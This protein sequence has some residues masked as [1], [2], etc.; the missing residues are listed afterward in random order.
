MSDQETPSAPTPAVDF[1]D[2]AG[3]DDL[4]RTLSRPPS[5]AG[6]TVSTDSDATVL[7]ADTFDLQKT[8]QNLI[9]KRD[10]A[11]I[12][13]RSL[14]VAFSE[15]EVIGRGS[16]RC[17]QHT[18]ASVLDPR[19]VIRAVQDFLHPPTRAILYGFEGVVRPGEM[20]LVLGQPGSG[21]STLL[22]T[23]TNQRGGYHAVNGDIRYD[24]LSS[25]DIERHYRGDVQYCPED[26]ILF[27]TL[28]VEQTIEFAVRARAPSQL[29]GIATSTADYVKTVTNI[30]ITVFGL[31]HVRNTPVGNAAIRGVSGGQRKRVSICEVMATMSRIA[32]WDN[33]TR[34]LDAST[35]LE[36][37]QALRIAT[38]MLNMTT[39]SSLYQVSEAIYQQFDKVCV[40]YEGR[41]A[42]FGLASEARQYFIDMGYKPVPRQTTADFLTSVTDPL[43]RV[44]RADALNVPRTA[45]EFDAYFK[46]SSMG[47]RNTRDVQDYFSIFTTEHA[48]Q[49]KQSAHAERSTLADKSSSYTTSL[50]AQTRAVVRRRLQ[51]V[52]GDLLTLGMN[53]GTFILLGVVVGTVFLKVEESTSAFFSRGSIFF[54]VLVFAAFQAMNEVSALFSQRIVVAQHQRAALYHPFVEALAHTV[55]DT[56]ISAIAVAIF[57]LLIYFI[58]RL[59]Q[60]AGQ[61]FL[62]FAFAFVS[63]MTMK[64]W[65]RAIAAAFKQNA[66]AQSAAG[67]SFLALSLF[68]GYTT[69]RPA[70]NDIFKWITV[71]NPLK[72]AF[73]GLMGNEFHSLIGW[74]SQI[75]P[76]G[77]G[78]EQVSLANQ[79]CTTVG[80][81]PGHSTV[82]GSQFLQLSFEYSYGHI[83]RDFGILWAFWAIYFMIQ[84]FLSEVNAGVSDQSSRLLFR[85]GARANQE[86]RASS[87]SSDE[88]AQ[89][90]VDSP[91]G[92]PRT[93]MSSGGDSEKTRDAAQQSSVFSWD[94]IN[95]T[96][97]VSGG[98]QRHLLHDVSGYVQPGRITALMG[99]SGAGKTTLLNV[100]AQRA[101]TG[102]VTGGMYVD[103]RSLP[104]DFQAQTGY[105]QQMDTHVGQTT[106]REAMVFSAKVRQPESVPIE[107]KEAY[108]D[109]CLKQC[110]LELFADAIVQ[111][112]DVEQRK[113]L[114]IGVEL[115]AKPKMIFLDEP[116]SGLDSNTSLAIVR[117]L[118]E[119]ANAGQSILCTI[120]QPSSELFASF[121]RILLLKKGG[122]T[123][124]FGDLGKHSTTLIEYFESH[125]ARRCQPVENPAEYMLEVIGAGATARVEQDWHHIWTGSNSYGAAMCTLEAMHEHSQDKTTD[126]AGSH[127]EFT[128]RWVYQ[129]VQLLKRSM[130][131][132]WR[133]P[134]YVVS[135]L[136]LNIVAGLFIGLTFKNAPNNQQGIQNTFMAF[137]IVLVLSLPLGFQIQEP[138]INMRSVYEIRERPS[139]MYKW[140]AFVSAQLVAEIPWNLLGSAFLFLTMYWL[141]FPGG[142]G[143]GYAYLMLGIVYPLYYSSFSMAVAAMVPRADLAAVLAIPLFSLALIFGGVLQPY[144]EMNWWR[145]MYW[146]SP[147]TYF[148]EGVIGA[149]FGNQTLE[150]AEKEYVTILPPSGMSCG[151]YLDPFAS[152]AGGYL[153]DP[154]AIDQCSFCPFR[155][156]DQFLEANSHMFY[157]HRWRDCGLMLAYVVFN[158]AMVY[159]LTWVFRIQTVLNR[160]R[161]HTA[162]GWLK[163]TK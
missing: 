91:D 151:E 81:V 9:Q 20:L 39:I 64:A 47:Q 72:Y 3:V 32:A 11:N 44:P 129:F 114:T 98:H 84:L 70:M 74:C 17:F 108:V 111:T 157:G 52:Q 66:A 103:G 46:R 160:R 28:T 89:L 156:T 76:Q 106:V 1:F 163:F 102:V 85:T 82:E 145:W 132:Q 31:G 92:S 122:K 43:A 50:V 63:Q 38:D 147:F 29:G 67:L 120:H 101:G 37:A 77:P 104:E 107:E 149:T 78:Y 69:P 49:F 144:S 24:A 105:V 152:F 86:F 143:A 30:L 137:L 35:A 138:F 21:C 125:G 4:R 33:S 14:G 16:S 136:L 118:R 59:Q 100:L 45:A 126:P 55:V 116:T 12:H 15:L 128:T 140:T 10:D 112:L 154:G 142:A 95:Y 61:F 162:L 65:F 54:F 146:V 68:I 93:V 79:A 134:M 7:D 87:E 6:S 19:R 155:T 90:G 139:R 127:K 26:E 57:S 88:E 119:L 73:E 94:R 5:R 36:F 80:S 97:T 109:K 131:A 22:K 58:C 51:I 124:Y 13:T 150:C 159:V 2:P 53:A 41:M 40:V 62:F 110:G 153:R 121:D 34:G 99:E 113:R 148:L 25:T 60:T 83:W 115:V 42:Y 48:T 123:V 75:I 117:F 18:V 96:V 71:V 27:P 133:D 135:K 56:P 141:V 161:V 23:L 8:L 130:L 158:V